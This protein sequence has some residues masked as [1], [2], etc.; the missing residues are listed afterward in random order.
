MRSRLWARIRREGAAIVEEACAW[1]SGIDGADRSVDALPD[2]RAEEVLGRYDL[3]PP[4]PLSAR[5]VF[6][7]Y[8]ILRELKATHRSHPF[9]PRTSRPARRWCSRD[10]VGRRGRRAERPGRFM[11][12]EWI[13]RRIDSLW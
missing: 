5:M 11:M 1:Q 13:A 12:E 2:G 4:P 6:E 9:S 7:G 8:R 3:A 10:A